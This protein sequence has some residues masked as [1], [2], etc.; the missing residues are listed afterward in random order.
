[1]RGSENTRQQPRRRA[2]CGR[3]A[4]EERAGV[5]RHRAELVG[6]G[7]E[8]AMVICTSTKSASAKSASRQSHAWKCWRTR[9][10]RVA[11]VRVVVAI[12]QAVCAEEG[13]Q[14][15]ELLRAPRRPVRRRRVRL[16][17]RCVCDRRRVLACHFSR[18]AAARSLLLREYRL[19]GQHARLRCE[20]S[21][22]VHSS[23][24][25]L[26]RAA[27]RRRRRHR[28]AWLRKRVADW[29]S[30][31]VSLSEQAVAASKTFDARHQSERQEAGRCGGA[32]ALPCVTRAH[33]G[34]GGVARLDCAAHELVRACCQAWE[35]VCTPRR[36]STASSTPPVQRGTRDLSA[37]TLQ[38]LRGGRACCAGAAACGDWLCESTGVGAAS[39]R[40]VK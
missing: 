36:R 28:R 38:R 24:R 8:T 15:R 20:R 10:R 23:T 25:Q 4:G 35:R 39:A 13:A 18:H 29:P 19:H 3:R 12:Q 21:V 5:V 14:V 11:G 7:F 31:P 33:G 40:L 22:H 27:P 26:Q 16:P 2:F 30:P 32:C 34:R 9:G 1:M 37:T 17:Q 6:N